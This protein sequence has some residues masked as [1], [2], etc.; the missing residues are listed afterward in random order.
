MAAMNPFSSVSWLWRAWRGRSITFAAFFALGLFGF[1]A[2]GAFRHGLSRLG[3]PWYVWL[4]VPIFIVTVLVRKEEE[5]LPDAE[6]RRKW[7]LRLI[8]GSI[9]LTILLAKLAPEKPADAGPPAGPQRGGRA[10]PHGR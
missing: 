9:F 1:S 5:W 8:F 3:A 7:S 6:E 10:D 4:L 2:V